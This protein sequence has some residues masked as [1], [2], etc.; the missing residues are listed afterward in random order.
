LQIKS[1]GILDVHL[2]LSKAISA[3]PKEAVDIAVATLSVVKAID[4][5]SGKLTP[6]GY[7]YFLLKETHGTYTR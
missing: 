6:L 7:F 1:L 5:K 3:P 2:M 4:H